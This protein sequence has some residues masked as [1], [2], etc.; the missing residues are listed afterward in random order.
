MFTEGDA[1]ECL[2]RNLVCGGI[3]HHTAADPGFVT[4]R[5]RVA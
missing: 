5:L 3:T 1:V 2:M 4:L